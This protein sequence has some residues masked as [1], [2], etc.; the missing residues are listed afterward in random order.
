M[1]QTVEA[2]TIEIDVVL[3]PED[4]GWIAQGLQFD[5][6]AR[7]SNPNEASERFDAKVGAEL[8]MSFEIGDENPLSGICPAP[9]QFWKMFEASQLRAERDETPIRITDGV[10]T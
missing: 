1:R 6:T 3:Y 8:V 4:S 7:G 2:A 5:I 9:Q 10:L